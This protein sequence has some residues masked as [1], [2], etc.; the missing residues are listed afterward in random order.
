MKRVTCSVAS[1]G[2]FLLAACATHHAAAPDGGKDAP[3]VPCPVFVPTADSLDWK[4]VQATGFTFCVPP[5]WRRSGS[6]GWQSEGAGIEWRIGAWPQSTTLDPR[7]FPAGIRGPE[8]FDRHLVE[9]I[10]GEGAELWDIR[11]QDADYTAAQWAQKRVFFKGKANGLQSADLEFTIYRT[12][13]FNASDL[14]G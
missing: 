13:R 10:G 1:I 4:L 14:G 8:H 3:P 11:I 2:A 5:G 9:V 6:R 7:W 12:V